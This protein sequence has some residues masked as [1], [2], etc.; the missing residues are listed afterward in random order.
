MIYLHC[1]SF[2]F[3]VDLESQSQEFTDGLWHQ[4]SLYIDKTMVNVTVDRNSKVSKRNMAISGGT[5][6]FLGM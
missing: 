4:F 2:T 6:Y 5:D 3:T 1:Q